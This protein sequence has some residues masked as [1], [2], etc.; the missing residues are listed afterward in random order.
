MSAP[1]EVTRDLLAEWP[2]P[3]P[4]EESDKEAR[5][6]VLVVGGSLEVPGA[7]RLAAE[8]ALRAGAGKLQA[9][10]P[11]DVAPV[12]AVAVPEARV[13]ALPARSGEIA[14][15]GA[16]ALGEVAGRCDAVVVGPGMLDQ[17]AAAEFTAALLRE[18][19]G[20]TLVLDAAAMGGVAKDPEA[21]R[22]HAGRLV[23]TPHAGEMAALTGADKEDV[24]AEPLAVARETA[25]ALKAVIVLKGRNTL[26]VSPD[27]R[28]WLHRLGVKGLATSGSGDVLAGVIGGLLARGA[29]PIQAA[30]WGV[31]LHGQAGARLAERV[32][33]LGF[34][35]R[36]IAAEIPAVMGAF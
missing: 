34:L 32:G 31:F 29:P 6:R 5:G 7:V 21:A 20:P 35:A 10:V 24:L 30:V 2:L 33:P 16:E 4:P 28:A 9:A 27:G 15:A 14:P 8:A 17:G 1:A 22:R 26:I 25:A 19:T 36:E 3:L 11:S 18:T 13:F 12:L 23:L